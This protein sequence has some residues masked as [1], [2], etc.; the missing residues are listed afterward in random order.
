MPRNFGIGIMSGTKRKQ[1]SC[2]SMEAAKSVNEEGM[3]LRQSARLYNVPVETLRRRVTGSVELDCRPGPSTVL[4]AEEETKLAE[5]VVQMADMGFG[6]S[7]EDFQTM[8]FRIV[9]KIGRPHPFQNGLAG[10]KWLSG[11]FA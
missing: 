10:P 1:W 3:G 9:D 8:A 11:F 5:Y 4:T 7:R 2:E 6:L